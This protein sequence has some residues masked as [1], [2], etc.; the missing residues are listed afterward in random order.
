MLTTNRFLERAP[1]DSE[2]LGNAGRRIFYLI[3]VPCLR[4][5]FLTL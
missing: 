4:V 1:D 3:P 5:L 2:G